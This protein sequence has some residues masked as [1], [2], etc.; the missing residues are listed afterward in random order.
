[1]IDQHTD[2]FKYVDNFSKTAH[3]PSISI[4]ESKVDYIPEITIAIPT[5]K[6]TDLLKEAI[7]SAINQ[8]DYTNYDIIVVDNNPERDCDT[9]KLIKSYNNPIISYYKNSE[10]LGMCGNWNRLF[11][12]AKGKY[13]VMLHDDD[14]L[15]PYYLKTLKQVLVSLKKEPDAVYF[16][17]KIIKSNMIDNDDNQF[18]NFNSKYLLKIKPFDFLFGNIVWII[19]A[20]FNRTTIINSG[21]FSENFYPSFD[22]AFF[23][24]LSKNM[25]S[26][27]IIGQHSTRYR[28][29]ENESL[30]TDIILKFI[31]MDNMIKKNILSNYSIKFNI[32]F[33][34]LFKV[35]DFIYLTNMSVL[36]NNNDPL[37]ENERIKML[38][39]ISYLDRFTSRL[40]IFMQKISFRL[41]RHIV[42]Q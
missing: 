4:I 42:N 1:M 30:K 36:F 22:Y 5:Y 7:D 26:Y 3:I 13:V 8:I 9:E 16:P 18:E 12:L 14:L 40:M 10:N 6:R 11:T 33:I 20:C 41:R 19:G 2:L 35:R 17:T 28:I 29:L 23:V 34:S 39:C 27:T 21:G 37:I 24:R 15:E 31:E 25:K 38:N 32:P